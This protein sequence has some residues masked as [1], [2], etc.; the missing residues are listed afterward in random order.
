MLTSKIVM[1][2]MLKSEIVKLGFITVRNLRGWDFEVGTLSGME[3]S[4]VESNNK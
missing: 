3:L 1:Y 4:K 2:E